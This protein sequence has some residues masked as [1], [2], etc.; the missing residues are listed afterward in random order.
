MVVMEEE[1]AKSQFVLGNCHVGG[2]SLA[3]EF[4][5]LEGSSNMDFKTLRGPGSKIG[6]KRVDTKVD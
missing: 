3:L 2:S 6:L 4:S 1:F 5:F